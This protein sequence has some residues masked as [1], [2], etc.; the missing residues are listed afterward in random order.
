[1]EIGMRQ[2]LDFEYCL[3]S[4]S[5][6]GTTRDKSTAPRSFKFL[7]RVAIA[8]DIDQSKRK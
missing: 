3:P 8:H 1:M 2:V 6:A 7:S 5:F 4:L